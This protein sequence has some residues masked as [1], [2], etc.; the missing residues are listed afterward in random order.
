MAEVTK[1]SP[2]A[3]AAILNLEAVQDVKT[4]T[5]RI[6]NDGPVITEPLLDVNTDVYDNGHGL[7][8][9]V[10]LVFECTDANGDAVTKTVVQPSQPFTRFAK[11]AR[12]SLVVSLHEDI[13]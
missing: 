10:G 8:A 7:L 11:V 12:R 2:T 3:E 6:T 5:V 4:R 9:H 13:A 1:G